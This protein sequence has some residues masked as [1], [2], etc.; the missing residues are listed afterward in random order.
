MPEHD[1][2][3]TGFEGLT[4]IITQSCPKCGWRNEVEFNETRPLKCPQCGSELL[5]EVTRGVLR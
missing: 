3:P 4:I 2:A 1:N 5:K